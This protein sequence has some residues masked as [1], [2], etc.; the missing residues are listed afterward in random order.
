[1]L[2]RIHDL[3][4]LLSIPLPSEQEMEARAKEMTREE[5]LHLR[6]LTEKYLSTDS[7]QEKT[8]ALLAFTGG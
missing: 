7:I 8:Q 5:L 6:G 3:E 1:M 2:Q 4:R